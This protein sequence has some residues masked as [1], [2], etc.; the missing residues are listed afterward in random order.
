MVAWTECL[1]IIEFMQQHQ[2]QL[3]RAAAEQRDIN[4]SRQTKTM[5]VA[6][7]PKLDAVNEVK[8]TEVTKSEK[9]LKPKENIE[10]DKDAV[11]RRSTTPEETVESMQKC[12]VVL[13]RIHIG[14][15][16]NHPATVSIKKQHQNIAVEAPR[17]IRMTRHQTKLLAEAAKK[18]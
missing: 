7:K 8:A 5:V 4:S 6:E 13:K 16:I 1:I 18:K 12:R 9:K 14:N 15:F 3:Y 2:E 17:N 11:Q 10:E